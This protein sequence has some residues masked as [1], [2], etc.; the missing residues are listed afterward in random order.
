MI[1]AALALALAAL[2]FVHQDIAP[3]RLTPSRSVT[4]EPALNGVTADLD[5][6]GH[7][8]LLFS[9][10]VALQ[11][12]GSFPADAFHAL[13]PVPAGAEADVWGVQLY[14]RHPGGL[15]VLRLRDSG[16]D[17]LADH[18]VAWPAGGSLETVPWRDE[19]AAGRVDL[20]R[21]LHDADAD[22]VPEVVAIDE[23]GVHVFRLHEGGYVADPPRAVLPALQLAPAPPQALWPAAQ[24]RI[25][26]PT[27]HMACRLNLDG[28]DLVR[29]TQ[30]PTPEGRVV[31]H[32][33]RYPD[34]LAGDAAVPVPARS[35]TDALPAHLRPLWT[36]QPGARAFAGV[37]WETAAAAPLPVPVLEAWITLDGGRSMRRERMRLPQGYHPAALLADVDGDGK[38]DLVAEESGLF[39]GGMREAALRFQTQSTLRHRV[40]V[41]PAEGNGFAAAPALDHEVRI[42]LDAPPGRHGR[43]FRSYQAGGMLNLT[44]DF[45]GDARLDLVVRDQPGR[46]AVHLQREGGF[47]AR[48]DATIPMDFDTPF[49]VADVNRDG[50]ADIALLW[51]NVA[52]G[53]AETITRV[54]FAAGARP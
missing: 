31:Y 30:E 23:A 13:P 17:T 15:R 14:L 40:R 22:G 48:P 8:D 26:V 53:S 4:G 35:S 18:A 24:R 19:A 39:D 46:I 9:E 2:E 1:A 41:Y 21:F 32:L 36:G 28:A 54:H 29:L 51:A 42:G 44:G 7:A 5:G 10:G 49:F 25:A 38:L 3:L 47:S 52:A 43:L 45:D 6:D 11:R 37:R 12:G 20:R 34:L 27:R 33:D 50:R 16:W